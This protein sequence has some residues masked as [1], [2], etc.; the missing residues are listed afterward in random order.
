MPPF[1]LCLIQPYYVQFIYHQMK[2]FKISW[3]KRKNSHIKF[4]K[5]ICE[6]FKMHKFCVEKK[7]LVHQ[8]QD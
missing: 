8:I 5:G 3:F 6:E 1:E 2:Y 4:R 7:N